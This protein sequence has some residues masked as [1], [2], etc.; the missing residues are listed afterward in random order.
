M[1]AA[2]NMNWNLVSEILS[3]KC[4]REL[5]EKRIHAIRRDVQS[6]SFRDSL[7]GP[8]GRMPNERFELCKRRLVQYLDDTDKSMFGSNPR[9]RSFTGKDEAE[10]HEL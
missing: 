2:G 3:A 1:L 6:T 5:M 8:F 4:S 7:H 9:L 10:S